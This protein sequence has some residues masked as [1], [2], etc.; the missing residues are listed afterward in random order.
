MPIYSA[1]INV[2]PLNEFKRKLVEVHNLF[3]KKIFKK[4]TTIKE[5]EIDECEEQLNITP[6][7]KRM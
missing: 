4:L 3:I 1:Y 2:M 6:C 7:L 5:Y